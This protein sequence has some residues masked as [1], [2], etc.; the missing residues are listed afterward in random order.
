MSFLFANEATCKSCA[1][2]HQGRW[3]R[4]AGMPRLPTI[5]T[6]SW[7]WIF[8]CDWAILKTSWLRNKSGNQRIHTRSECPFFLHPKQIV[9]FRFSRSSKNFRAS[10]FPLF[11]RVSSTSAGFS[12]L[13][14][15]P[16]TFLS[17][18]AVRF[19][20]PFSEA[21]TPQTKL[22]HNWSHA[23]SCGRKWPPN[24][25][26]SKRCSDTTAFAPLPFPSSFC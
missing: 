12:L 20:G 15:L 22:R 10:C 1:S 21:L 19:R 9:P 2:I 16:A 4:F 3:T 23:T 8:L 11:W 26:S 18:F 5:E 6:E 14:L 25:S 7:S 24:D 17:M 13:R